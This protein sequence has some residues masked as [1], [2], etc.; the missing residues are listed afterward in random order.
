MTIETVIGYG[1]I[2][3]F[4]LIFILW[5]VQMIRFHSRPRPTTKPTQKPRKKPR[6]EEED[7][8][9]FIDE[10]IE[11][12]DWE[13]EDDEFTEEIDSTHGDEDEFVPL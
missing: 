6:Y 11:I 5:L 1:L 9:I 7:Q 3:G 13:T 4:A 10:K 12:E 2:Y 8:F